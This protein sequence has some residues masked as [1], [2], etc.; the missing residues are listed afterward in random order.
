MR[1]VIGMNKDKRL[2]NDI[3]KKEER[4]LAEGAM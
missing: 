3:R 4:V 2:K 1:K